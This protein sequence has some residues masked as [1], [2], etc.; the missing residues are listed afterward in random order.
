MSRLDRSDLAAELRQ[1]QAS[2]TPATLYRRQLL[3]L[4]VPSVTLAMLKGVEAWGYGVVKASAGEGG[5]YLPGEGPPHLLLPVREDGELVDL[6]A[7]RS[8]EPHNWRLRAGNGWALGMDWGLEPFTRG[9]P[10]PVHETP[11]DWLKAKMAGICILDWDA[12]DL[13]SL[14]AIERLDCATPELARML[15]AALT[16]PANLP[17]ISV[18]ENRLAA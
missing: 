15:R 3:A 10:V 17:L 7:F 14:L 1:A 9:W 2:A 4:G 13:F 5:L 6:V 11:L 12:P 8:S 16:R 18:R